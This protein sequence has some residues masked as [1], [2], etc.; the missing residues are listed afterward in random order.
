[1]TCTYISG[2]ATSLATDNDTND[3]T[4]EPPN[5]RAR[6]TA[7]TRPILSDA[8]RS[9]PPAPPLCTGKKHEMSMQAMNTNGIELENFARAA[10]YLE[11]CSKP[12]ADHAKSAISLQHVFKRKLIGVLALN[13][14]EITADQIK[15]DWCA[16][17]GSK[18]RRVQR[19]ATRLERVT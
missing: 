12:D 19:L 1:M 10:L 14:L 4:L 3:D 16:R 13:D 5:A 17:S 8:R 11:A 15:P 7:Q 9:V 2:T 6:A 18:P